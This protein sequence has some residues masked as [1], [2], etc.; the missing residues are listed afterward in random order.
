MAAP[1]RRICR[2]MEHNHVPIAEFHTWS[3]GHRT[4]AKW[5]ENSLLP[6]E[7]EFVWVLGARAGTV[8]VM[9]FLKAA[10]RRSNV[11]PD[12]T[13]TLPRCQLETRNPAGGGVAADCICATTLHCAAWLKAGFW[14]VSGGWST[15]S[16]KWP[17][18]NAAYRGKHAATSQ[19]CTFRAALGARTLL[20]AP[21]LTT[22]NKKLL[23]PR[24]LLVVTGSYWQ[25]CTS[26]SP[27]ATSEVRL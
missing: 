4:F 26:R 3:K 7:S 1:P 8:H 5:D 21:G 12:M 16:A 17:W 9:A 27:T 22:R 11:E 15:H 20:V 2:R 6:K 24:A 19:A 13:L 25:S 18:A 23:A 10:F 14:K